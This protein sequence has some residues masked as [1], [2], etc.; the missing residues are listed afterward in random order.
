MPKF[1]RNVLIPL[2]IICGFSNCARYQKQ[3]D[4]AVLNADIPHSS[5]TGAWTGSW[6]ST[7]T[8]HT[9]KLKCI[10]QEKKDGQYE[11]YYWATWAR[12]ISGG[13]RITCS[14]NKKNEK[15]T[16]NGEKD[17]GSLGGNFNHQG[18]G[19]I[20]KIEASYQ[21]D[22]GDHGTFTLTRP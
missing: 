8:G 6:K 20:N 17:L 19:N 5:I 13:F 22:R 12:V 14:V 2:L 4:K 16:F 10:I 11:F 15:W 7:P 18:K 21:S 9:G 3:W 1:I